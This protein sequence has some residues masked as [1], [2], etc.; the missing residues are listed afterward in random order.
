[1]RGDESLSQGHLGCD[2]GKTIT[3]QTFL[4]SLAC[5]ERVTRP[6]KVSNYC[7]CLKKVKKRRSSVFVHLPACVKRVF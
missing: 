3:A 4:F 5:A 1:M 7:I 2:R 6:D